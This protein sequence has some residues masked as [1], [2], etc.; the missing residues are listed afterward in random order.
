MK[1]IISFVV[2]LGCSLG[3]GSAAW[4]V[5]QDPNFEVSLGR[6]KNIDLGA[7]K[8]RVVK[9]GE[10]VTINGN[11]RLWLTGQ[12]D[13]A[14]YYELL[15][16]NRSSG[17]VQ[18]EITSNE[19][20]WLA[21]SSPQ[22]CNAWSGE[23]LVC[24]ANGLAKGVF[25]KVSKK[26][27]QPP[28]SVAT[29]AQTASVGVRAIELAED[30]E[31]QVD[32]NAYLLQIIVRYQTGIELCGAMHGVA[33]PVV[34]AWDIYDGGATGKV[35]VDREKSHQQDLGRAECIADQIQDWRFPRWKKDYRVAYRF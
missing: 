3:L 12:E 29:R 20:P 21:V 13:A 34:I 6:S 23:L 1:G 11:G 35:E 17:D 25:C 22:S 10:R 8:K 14:G 33:G 9:V 26:S 4:A 7:D 30:Q 31:D 24:P 5:A 27:K 18:V 2:A 19:F 28:M 15:C 32:Y 16:Q